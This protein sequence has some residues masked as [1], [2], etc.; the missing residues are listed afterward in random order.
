M[1]SFISSYGNT[2]ILVEIDYVSN[3]VEVV[4]IPKNEA[5]SVVAFLKNNIFTR[6]GTPRAIISYGDRISAIRSLILC[7]KSMV[8]LTK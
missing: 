5:R 2:Y 8:S 1:G 6:F 4:A 3:W 7:L